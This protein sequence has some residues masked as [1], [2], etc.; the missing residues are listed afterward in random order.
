MNIYYT[1]TLRGTYNIPTYTMDIRDLTF[2]ASLFITTLYDRYIGIAVLS[3]AL[4][5]C[6]DWQ[7][8]ISAGYIT[9]LLSTTYDVFRAGT[10]SIVPNYKNTLIAYYIVSGLCT[11][12]RIAFGRYFFDIELFRLPEVEYVVSDEET[13]DSDDSDDSDE[14]DDENKVTFEMYVPNIPNTPTEAPTEAPTELPTE[15]TADEPTDTPTESPTEVPADTPTELPT[16]VT[17][18]DHTD[19]PTD[20]AYTS[21]PD[22]TIIHE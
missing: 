19:A 9:M 10:L 2:I 13:D 4:V 7:T 22:C 18:D 5:R 8:I 15:V 20:T 21:D 11:L 6:T 14:S 1:T 16:E 3:V 12:M 17:A